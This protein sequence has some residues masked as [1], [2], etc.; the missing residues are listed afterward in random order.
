MLI[1]I[2]YVCSYKCKLNPKEIVV[3]FVFLLN[4]EYADFSFPSCETKSIPP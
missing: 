4:L 1:E 3:I 2:S